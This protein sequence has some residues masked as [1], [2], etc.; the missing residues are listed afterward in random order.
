MAEN[1]PK[2]R[3]VAADGTRLGVY[4][5]YTKNVRETMPAASAEY[6]DVSVFYVGKPSGDFTPGHLY[7]CIK[8]GSV[9]GW[10]DVTP[11]GGSAAV[12]EYQF[13]TT[14]NTGNTVTISKELLGVDTSYPEYDLI[15]QDGYNVSADTRIARRWNKVNGLYEIVYLGGW[16]IGTW[17][18]KSV[19]QSPINLSSYTYSKSKIEE[20]IA[21][22]TDKRIVTVAGTHA[23]IDVVEPNTYYICTS[24][25]QSLE[26]QEVSHSAKE[27]AVFC[28]TNDNTT[29]SV[30]FPAS[31]QWIATPTFSKGKNY[32][33]IFNYGIAAASKL[34]E[35]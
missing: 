33:V 30:S 22:A 21:G 3:L 25:L 12:A 6:A 11:T 13:T 26:I 27:S 9:Y 8:E 7:T 20:L 19:G 10:V 15:D 34:E 5:D 18:L 2:I 17:T 4:A 32:V 31:L 35:L 28:R 23:Y 16:P 24:T 1:R 29:C 14:E